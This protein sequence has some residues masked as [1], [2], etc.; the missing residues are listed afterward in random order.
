VKFDVGVFHIMPQSSEGLNFLIFFVIYIVVLKSFCLN[1]LQSYFHE[2]IQ[3]LCIICDLSVLFQ[4]ALSLMDSTYKIP[5]LLDRA[6]SYSA[7]LMSVL[8]DLILQNFPVC[9]PPYKWKHT[10]ETCN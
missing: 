6:A 8:S 4:S 3:E 5:L 7:R 10:R 2:P 9:S 1:R